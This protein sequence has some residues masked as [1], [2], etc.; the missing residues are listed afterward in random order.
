MIRRLNPPLL[1]R[2]AAGTWLA[3]LAL[4]AR[5]PGQD[6]DARVLGNIDQEASVRREDKSDK[7]DKPQL[8]ERVTYSDNGEQRTVAGRVLIEAQD[9]GLL[10]E[11]ADG[12]QHAVDGRA[13]LSRQKTDTKFKPLSANELGAE[14]LEKLPPGFRIHTT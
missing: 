6:S 13:I 11:S 10:V 3:V 2:T 12:V 5:A 1:L 9:G 14:L 4:A 7:S 8:V